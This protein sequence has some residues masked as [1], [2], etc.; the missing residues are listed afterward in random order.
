MNN[1]AIGCYTRF[2]LLWRP[3]VKNMPSIQNGQ[4]WSFY[5]DKRKSTTPKNGCT[6]S[7]F[8][9]MAF[10]SE[11]RLY[12]SALD[13][14]HP[15]VRKFCNKLRLIIMLATAGVTS[16]GKCWLAKTLKKKGSSSASNDAIIHTLDVWHYWRRLPQADMKVEVRIP[17][18]S[19]KRQ[20]TAV[21]CRWDDERGTRGEDIVI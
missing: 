19:P 14:H 11:L 18:N 17:S 16:H 5:Q 21:K 13:S 7:W 6:Y 15:I 10:P 4:L 8:F 20:T 3:P 1:V 2:I 12:T 9:T